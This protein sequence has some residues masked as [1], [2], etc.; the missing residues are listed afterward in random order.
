MKIALLAPLY[1]SVPPK[2][3]G[4]TERVVFYLAEELVNQGHEVVLFASGDSVTQAELVPLCS[5]ALWLDKE[6]V[7]TLAP[8]VL[9]MERFFQM[10]PEFDIIHNHADYLSFPLLRRSP[11]QTVSTLHGRLDIKE[12]EPLYAEFADLSL[13]SI[14]WAQQKPLRGANWVGNVYHGLPKDLY[15]FHESPGEYLAFLGRICPD[16]GVHSAIEIAKKT[17]IPLKIAAKVVDNKYYSQ[18]IEPQIDG[19]F[20]EY[21]G[22]ICEEEKDLFLGNAHALLAPIDWPEPFGL[23]MIEAMACGTPVIARERGSVPEIIEKGVNGFVIETVEEAV[24]ALPEV[25]KI[26]RKRCRDY[27][28]RYFTDKRMAEDYLKIYQ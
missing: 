12:L 19:S 26:S 14:S 15:R 4:G 1:E 9:M 6:C 3:Y 22:E 28:E 20:I 13:V 24:K 21:V 10:A 8:H 7:D 23:C 16:K 2:F 25:S 17:G 27:F 11:T 18:I 5:K